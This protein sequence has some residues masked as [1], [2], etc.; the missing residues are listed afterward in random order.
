MVNIDIERGSFE[1]ALRN[2]ELGHTYVKFHEGNGRQYTYGFY[3]ESTVPNENQRTV[4]GCVRH[5]DRTHES[6]IDDRVTFS[7]T[8]TQYQAALATAQQICRDRHTYGVNYTCTTYAEGVATAAGQSL[9]PSRSAPMAIFYQQVPP[10]DNPNTLYE[11]VQAERARDPN[12]RFPLW[13]NPCVNECEA[14][15]ERCLKTGGRGLSPSLPAQCMVARERCNRRC[16][17]AG[18]S[19]ERPR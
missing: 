15:F 5:P 13:N 16:P 17:R 6:C 14:A 11:S 2:Q 9:P 1:S 4:P 7:L 8:Q 10:I 3:P 19:R 12:R 18:S